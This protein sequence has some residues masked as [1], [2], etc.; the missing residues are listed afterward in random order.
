M[1]QDAIVT[2]LLPGG[3]AEVAVTRGTAC[4]GNCGNCESCMFQSELKVAASNPLGA[5]PGQKVVIESKS[6]KIYKATLLVYIFPMLLLV[7][8]YAI[9]ALAGAGEGLSIL[10]SFL[11]LALGG[12][13]IV[14]SQRKIK[15]KDRITFKIVQIY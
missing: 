15:K 5:K 2:K 10:A 9:A 1:T 8:G 3:M 6:S 11:G 4:G 12:A 14:L 7:L 13:I